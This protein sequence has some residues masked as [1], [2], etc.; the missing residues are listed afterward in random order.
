MSSSN[1]S[2]K[3]F[4]LVNLAL[5]VASLNFLLP[6]CLTHAFSWHKSKLFISCLTPSH[7]G[8]FLCLVTS[9]SI[10][11]RCVNP[12]ALPLNSTHRAALNI[13]SICFIFLLC[14][15]SFSYKL[16]KMLSRCVCVC[17]C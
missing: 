16:V 8:C 7:H 12:S 2:F 15:L 11:V 14:W 4:L 5:P 13:H 6:L 1:S 9:V 3:D 17:V 10:T